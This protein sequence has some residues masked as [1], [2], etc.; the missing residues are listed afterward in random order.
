MASFA[1]RFNDTYRFGLGMGLHIDFFISFAFW[2]FLQINF[3]DMPNLQ[4]FK[5]E[6][7][8]ELD[9]RNRLVSFVHGLVALVLSGYAIY[10]F[11]YGCGDQ[12]TLLQYWILALSGGYFTYDLVG[13]KLFGLLTFDML[14]HHLLCIFGILIT[15]YQGHDA[16]HVVAGLF[17]AEV[18]NP[19][20]HVR[21]MLRNLGMRYTKIHDTAEIIYFVMF[22][23]G[24]VLI[25]HPVVYDTVMCESTPIFAKL[26][27]L[28]ILAQSYQFLA[29]MYTLLKNR[30][31]EIK[32]RKQKKIK[33]MWFTPL[34]A[35][36]VAKLDYN[37]K[38]TKDGLP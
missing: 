32:E 38:K 29:R 24:R 1:D 21:T 9:F 2:G 6:R 20:M 16:C 12:N 23:F 19:A 27:S 34:P 18:S 5:M 33:M 30:I 37:L 10:F 4:R 11:E 14:V 22:F 3:Y 28:G 36:Q 35:E 25:G 8:T 7:K 31:A 17:V 26:V 13:M 15:L